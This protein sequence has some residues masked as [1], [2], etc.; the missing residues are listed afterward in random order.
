M[1]AK[2]AVL[3]PRDRMPEHDRDGDVCA[4]AP[5]SPSAT[6]RES[7]AALVGLGPLSPSSSASS[8]EHRQDPHSSGSTS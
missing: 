3:D 6:A 4:L 1:T 7:S 5:Q 2:P 8:R